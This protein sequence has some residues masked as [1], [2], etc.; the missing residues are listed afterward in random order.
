MAMKRSAFSRLQ[1]MQK[2]CKHRTSKFAFVS[3][4]VVYICVFM[5]ENSLKFAYKIQVERITLSSSC[6][7][8]DSTIVGKNCLANNMILIH[9]FPIRLDSLFHSTISSASHFVA[10]AFKT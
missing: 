10:I 7:C 6:M 3:F 8:F 9:I 5:F 2:L 4:Q 1:I